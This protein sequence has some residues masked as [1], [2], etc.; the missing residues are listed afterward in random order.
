MLTSD[1]IRYISKFCDTLTKFNI[2]VYILKNTTSFKKFNP[3]TLIEQN[4]NTHIFQELSTGVLEIFQKSR[5]LLHFQ[6]DYIESTHEHI[7]DLVITNTIN[8][9]NLK[10][11]NIHK[12]KLIQKL[13]IEEK[14]KHI[15][16]DAVGQLIFQP[17]IN[18]TYLNCRLD[19]N[20]NINLS[21]LLQI[22]NL[23]I[24]ILVHNDF[25][26]SRFLCLI[27]EGEII[28]SIYLPLD[29]SNQILLDL[30]NSELPIENLEIYQSY[31]YIS[32]E[33]KECFRKLG[34]NI[35]GITITHAVNETFDEF[36]SDNVIDYSKIVYDILG[37]TD[38]KMVSLYGFCNSTSITIDFRNL[39][40]LEY[41]INQYT[42]SN[43]IVF[44]GTK[45]TKLVTNLIPNS[46][47]GIR[48]LT[49]HNFYADKSVFIEPN[50]ID[51]LTSFDYNIEL[52]R[53]YEYLCLTRVVIKSIRNDKPIYIK[54]L[55]LD[56]TQILQ[57][58][59][60]YVEH[61]ELMNKDQYCPNLI[62]RN[63][64]IWLNEFECS[65][66]L[67][68]IELDTLT[69]KT[70]DYSPFANNRKFVHNINCKTNLIK[71]DNGIDLSD[72]IKRNENVIIYTL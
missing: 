57:N 18:L 32:S 44:F 55:V 22:E 48:E 56:K 71:I 49:L 16:I 52:T 46:L 29:K 58:Q 25:F 37:R 13:I 2:E 33:L 1:T 5:A 36:I 62:T 53:S 40:E 67:N 42:S 21:Q 64:T 51:R 15:S 31:R 4:G 8:W 10:T 14:W 43:N 38:L 61:L 26:H 11:V 27:K 70:K 72:D 35:Q 50:E 39:P 23:N 17:K 19:E 41:L 12:N 59:I 9:K 7:E 28:K 24:K 45:I 34:H 47:T 3:V 30:L 69:L 20:N 65:L 66:D 63:I 60:I 6:T 68:N 54:H